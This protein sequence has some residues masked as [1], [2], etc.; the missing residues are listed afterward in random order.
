MVKTTVKQEDL[1]AILEGTHSNPHMVLGIHEVNI[2]GQK[3]YSIRAYDPWAIKVFVLYDGNEIEMV[4]VHPLGFFEALINKDEFFEYELKFEFDN[5][6]S[7]IT[8]DPYSFLPTISEYDLYL[9]GEGNNE[10][11]Y[12]KMGA[13]VR[14]INGVKGVS[15]VV[16]A[17]GVKRVSVV[18]D[19]NNWDGR[20]HP[21]RVL[22]NSGVWEIFIPNLIEGTKYKFEILTHRNQLLLKTD[23]Y[24]LKMELRPKTASIIW[25]IDKYEWNDHEWMEKRKK[26]NPFKEPLLI[27]EVHLGSWMRKGDGENDFLNYRELAHKLAAY[28]LEMGYNYVELLPIMEHPLD[29]SWGYQVTGYYAVTSR[30]G[31]PE[32]FMYFVDYMHQNG[33]GVILDWVPGHFPKD[34]FAL[35]NFI[36]EPLYEYA[37]PRKGEHKDWGTKIFDYGK[38]EVRNFLIANAV[39]WADKYHIDG[40]RVDAVASMLYLDYSRGPGEWVPNEYGGNENLEAIFFIRKLNEVMHGRY[41]GLIMI[42][43]E[44]TSWPAVSRPTYIGGLGFT[45]KWNMGWMNDFLHYMSLDPIF[46]K[47]HHNNLTFTML[48]NYSENFILVISHDEVVHGKRSLLNKMPGNEWDK[49]AN[50]RLALS[51]MIGHPGKKLLFMGCDI[52]Q[53][54]EWWEA[55]SLDWYLLQYEPHYKLN[56]F[57]RDLNH[58]YQNEPALYEGDHESWGFEWIDCNDW[59]NSIVSFIRRASNGEYLIFVFN[60]T[61]V[62]RLNYRIGVPELGYYKEVLNSDS[63]LYWGSNLGNNGGVYAEEIPWQNKPYSM[64]ILLPPFSCLVFKKQ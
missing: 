24:A 61:P 52:G 47:Y 17:P 6:T 23:P 29:A 45:F 43:E 41:P 55:R 37:D 20:R 33:I 2:D 51:F 35:A 5:G 16:W 26:K 21:M 36:G 22:G 59:E 30:M 48:Y 54:N 44:S 3:I 39:F 57:V 25:D 38:N 49:F 60:F 15:F 7:Y 56:R 19:F 12:K 13:R 63:A 18:G 9:F 32:D 14:E 10:E 1:N 27:Y 46:R 40:L 62:T 58:L 4:R 53:W 64:N 28:V 34:D 42:A 11:I 50:V 31:D 8:K